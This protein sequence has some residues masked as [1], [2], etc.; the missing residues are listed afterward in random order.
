MI[1]NINIAIRSSAPRLDHFALPP[2]RPAIETGR[3]RP[4]PRVA[5]SERI[6]QRSTE[7]SIRH[8][9]GASRSCEKHCRG[10]EKD[11]RVMEKDTEW[12]PSTPRQHASQVVCLDRM[13]PGGQAPNFHDFSTSVTLCA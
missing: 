13:R 5:M 12:F 7:W 4:K 1:I 3:S 11:L 6:R 8:Q 9:S 10:L 2:N